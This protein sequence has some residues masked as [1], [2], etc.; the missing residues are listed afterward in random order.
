M[1][2][3]RGRWRAG[4]LLLLCFLGGAGRVGAQGYAGAI[5]GA[6]RDSMSGGA[7]AVAVT[8][9]E[10]ASGAV[11]N[12]TTNRAGE[13]VFAALAPGNYRLR[14][15]A[16]GFKPIETEEFRIGSQQFVTLPDFT[17]QVA[18]REEEIVVSGTVGQ[19]ER[20]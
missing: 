15:A 1:N 2:A 10:T 12:T 18:G 7:A 11:R 19:L 8:A 6:V 16:A 20:S 3:A 14:I 9:M 4:Y 17:L 5:R 13:Y